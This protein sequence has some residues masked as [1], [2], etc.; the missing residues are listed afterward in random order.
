VDVV[1]PEHEHLHE[2]TDPTGWKIPL[3]SKCKNERA[4]RAGVLEFSDP[5]PKRLAGALREVAAGGLTVVIQRQGEDFQV[6]LSATE[7]HDGR[8]RFLPGTSPPFVRLVDGAGEPPGLAGERFQPFGVLRLAGHGKSTPLELRSLNWHATE[9]DDC[10]EL[11]V[12]VHAILRSDQWDVPLPLK[13]KSTPIRELLDPEQLLPPGGS[14]GVAS[15]H[16]PTRPLPVSL[17]FTFKATST[18][19]VR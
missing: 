12:D 16:V 10:S 2:H 7:P 18:L 11:T 9:R 15:A 1:D 5:T 14:P 6:A 17:H 4:F 8:E 13:A 19:F 3:T